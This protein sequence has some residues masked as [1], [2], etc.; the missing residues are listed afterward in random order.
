[1]CL[2]GDVNLLGLKPNKLPIVLQVS[3]IT[4]NIIDFI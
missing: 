4:I 2:V 3:Q 1:M